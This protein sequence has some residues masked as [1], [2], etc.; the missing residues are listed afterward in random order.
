MRVY[1]VQVGDSPASIASQDA[2]AGCPKCSRDLVLANPHKPTRTL[3]NGYVTFTDLRAGEKLVLPEKWWSAEFEALPPSY[4]A[5][6][7][8]PDGVT[9][10][11]KGTP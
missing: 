4:F 5:S 9:P 11:K 1:E 10:V 2:H 7:P 8:H 3:P 6:L